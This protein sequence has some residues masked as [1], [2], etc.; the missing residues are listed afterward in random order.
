MN[1]VFNL[2]QVENQYMIRTMA[3]ART[4]LPHNPRGRLTGLPLCGGKVIGSGSQDGCS[5]ARV[6]H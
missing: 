1:K 5:A 4:S 3:C 2:D 6:S